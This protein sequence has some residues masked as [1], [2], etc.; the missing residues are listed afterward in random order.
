MKKRITTLVLASVLATT[1][2]GCGGSSKEI[3][4]NIPDVNVISVDTLKAAG[5]TN[6]TFWHSFTTTAVEDALA[7]A[8]ASFEKEYPYIKVEAVSKGGYDNLKSA[9]TLEIPTGNTPNVVIGYPDHFSEYIAGEVLVPLDKYI[10]S[11]EVGIDVSDYYSSYMAEVTSLVDGYTF[12]LPFNKSTEVLSYN[13]TFF[14]AHNLKVP[15]TW[16]EVKD[17]AQKSYDIIKAV[18]ATESKIDTVSGIDFSSCDF[19]KF[20]PLSYDAAANQF[21]TYVQQWGGTYTELESFDK[22]HIKFDSTETRTMLSWVSEMYTDHLFAPPAV[23]EQ[24]YA[25]NAGAFQYVMSVG[26]SAGAQYYA[27]AANGA[28][29]VGVAAVPYKDADHKYVIQQGT[30][31]AMLANG[32]DEQKLASWLL[33]KYLTSSEVNAEFAIAAGYYPVSKSATASTVYQNFLNST[34]DTPA[35]ASTLAAAK[36]NAEVYM[37]EYKSYFSP[38]FVGSSEVRTVVGN[39]IPAITVSGQ[40]IEDALK[41]AV[42]Q[43]PNYQ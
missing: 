26:S 2:V 28:Y 30:N 6:I 15:T 24:S 38:A 9:V 12:G 16:D 5:T 20:Y 31:I 42:S 27:T 4:Y 19:S 25:N 39:I 1:L 7:T 35:K 11:K 14:D 37:T 32:T 3:S 18:M 8:L 33:I 22:G 21:I 13:K 43:L 41:D 36:V 23:W 17:V 34:P 40:S 29:E 10:A